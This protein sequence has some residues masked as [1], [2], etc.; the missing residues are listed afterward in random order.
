[1]IRLLVSAV[2]VLASLVLVAP[3]AAYGPPQLRLKELDVSDR[4]VGAWRTLDGAQLHS[5]NG[6]ELGV[7]LQ[8]SGQHVLVEL[9]AVPPSSTVA[10]QREVYDLCFENTGTPGEVVDLDQRIRYAGNG[11]YGVR[12][13]VS[14]SP[15]A[16]TSCKT[17]NP[18]TAAGAF[19]VDA[20]TVIRRVGAPQLVLDA[21]DP[22]PAFGGWVVDPPDLAGRAEVRCSLGGTLTETLFAT[23][24]RRMPGEPFAADFGGLPRP[25]RW[26]CAGH[27]SAGGALIPPGFSEPVGPELVREAWYGLFESA[28]RG[29]AGNAGVTARA[30]RWYAGA[31]VRLRLRRAVCGSRLR[32]ITVAKAKVSRAGRLAFHFRLPKLHR[33]QDFAIYRPETTIS[34]SELVV[35]RRREEDTLALTRDGLQKTLTPCDERP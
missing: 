11:T 1:M 28:F 4:P 7:V 18:A 25:G 20:Q 19:T 17:A 32:T 14:D 2:A 8:Q 16:S 26:T 12:M 9:T 29:R 22:S 30:E 5:A 24:D 35:S 31:I 13:T 23:K 21:T 27:Q 15:D 34:G 10:D 6:F 33:F 3:A